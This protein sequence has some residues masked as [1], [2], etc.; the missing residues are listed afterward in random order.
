[1]VPPSTMATNLLPSDE[2]A[3]EDHFREPEL[4]RSVQV[5]PAS[6]EV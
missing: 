1:M 3:T 5:A 2:L 6:V 4:F